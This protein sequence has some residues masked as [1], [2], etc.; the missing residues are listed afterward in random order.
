MLMHTM[1][2]SWVRESSRK[3]ETG[4]VDLRPGL[5]HS[6]IS[7]SRTTDNSSLNDVNVEQRK[8]RRRLARRQQE[9]AELE[10]QFHASQQQYREEI[11]PLK[12]EML[13]RQ[14]ERLRRA[15]QRHMRSARHRNAYHDAQRAYEAFRE[16][17]PTAPSPPDEQI[18]ALYRRASKRCH[19]DVVPSVH[20]EQA[21]ATFQALRAAYETGHARAVKAIAHALE[22]WGF[23]QDADAGEKTERTHS[24]DH[25]RRA[26]ST[27]ESSIQAIRGTDAYQDLVEAGDLDALLHARKKQLRRRLRNLQRL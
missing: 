14:T 8:L 20:R 22:Q 16:S 10:R 25:L 15:A 18:K 26:I 11:A 7:V 2:R 23:P 1:N 21:A 12:E 6:K 5:F 17:R 3:I 27:L 4:L 24:P 13:R 19:P 9:K